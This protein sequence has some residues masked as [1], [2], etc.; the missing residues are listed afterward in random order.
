VTVSGEGRLEIA[1]AT[2]RSLKVRE[3][4]ALLGQKITD[5]TS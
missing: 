3:L 4:E 1:E 5:A 2:R